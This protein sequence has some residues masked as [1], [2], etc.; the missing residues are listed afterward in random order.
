MNTQYDDRR[1]SVHGGITS[2]APVAVM[3]IEAGASLLIKPTAAGSAKVIV[4]NDAIAACVV[5]IG[6]GNFTTGQAAWFDWTPGTVS[7]ATQSGVDY[8][9]TAA[10]CVPASGTWT[11]VVN[12]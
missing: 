5:D 11:F 9:I 8:R 3:E 6:S 7:I 4:S 10:V 12:R 2:A 1:Q